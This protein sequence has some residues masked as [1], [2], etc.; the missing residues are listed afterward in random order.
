MNDV[1]KEIYEICK[2]FADKIK[3]VLEREVNKE[4]KG[5]DTPEWK[6]MILAEYKCEYHNILCEIKEIEDR[7]K[8]M[9]GEEL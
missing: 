5:Y 8:I 1:K 3:V 6:A 7:I 9:V 2:E 4:V